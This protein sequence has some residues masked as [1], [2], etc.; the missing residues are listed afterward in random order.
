MATVILALGLIGALAAFSLASRA[1]GAS[2]NDTIVPL[3]AEQKLSE[4]KSFPRDELKAGAYEGDFG[5]DYPGYT[6]SL[7]LD[8]PDDRHVV[9]VT[10]V[11]HSLEMGHTR[12]ETFATQLF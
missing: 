4:L 12:D 9:T 1:T 7:T 3:L 8:E 2:R 11:I 6:W 10:L 5:G